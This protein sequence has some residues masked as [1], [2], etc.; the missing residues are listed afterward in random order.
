MAIALLERTKPVQLADLEHSLKAGVS[1]A[2][3]LL[4]D[5]A[6]AARDLAQLD[7]VMR[8]WTESS[9]ARVKRQTLRKNISNVKS[10]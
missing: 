5:A 8:N 1:W 6:L 3:I 9:P 4:V 7:R 2:D 10:P